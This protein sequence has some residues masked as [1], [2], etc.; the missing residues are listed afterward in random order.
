M[1]VMGRRINCSLCVQDNSR[2]KFLIPYNVDNGAL[3][4]QNRLPQEEIDL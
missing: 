1:A 4:R 3:C 2:R